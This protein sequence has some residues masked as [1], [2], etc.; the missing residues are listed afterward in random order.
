MNDKPELYFPRNVEWRDWL[1]QHH[2]TYSLGVYLIFYKLETNT[3]TMRWE[4][5]V[6]VALCYGWI[7]STVQSLGNGK[8][9][10]F[11]CPRN[12]KSSWSK[13]NKSYIEELELQDL[14]ASSGWKTI[15][16]AKETG[17]WTAMD[18]VE[19]LEIPEDL[20]KSFDANYLAFEN[21]Q[22]FSPSYRKSYLSW[23]HNAKRKTTRDKRILEIITLCGNN[24]K[25]RM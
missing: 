13:L 22:N 3:P 5:A 18:V 21:Y 16:L 11:F 10:Q 1:D 7:D 15:D 19:N 2:S 23:L 8:R 12:P 14:V 9:R 6:K 24:I 25:S 4:E 20:K 17:T